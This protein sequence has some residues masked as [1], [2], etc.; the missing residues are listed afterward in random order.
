MPCTNRNLLKNG[1]F[2]SGISPWTG[3]GINRVNNP[4]QPGDFSILMKSSAANN[5]VLKQSIQGPFEEDCA[6]YLNFRVLNVTPPGN[7]AVLYAA[8]SYLN[9]KKNLIRT[10]PLLIK[11]PARTSDWYSYF[12]I[13]PP[14]PRGTRFATVV[15]LLAKG[16][17][18]VDYIRFASHSI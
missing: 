3:M 7:E 1:S 4:F 2:R 12:S 10:T 5:A 15:F 13:V 14:P 16:N 9:R 18:L 8:V 11:P 17:L 6:Y